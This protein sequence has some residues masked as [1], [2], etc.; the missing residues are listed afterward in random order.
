M[1]GPDRN[2]RHAEPGSPEAL[3]GEFVSD[4]HRSDCARFLDEVRSRIDHRRQADRDRPRLN[5]PQ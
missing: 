3:P 4:E 5:P 1:D 2:V